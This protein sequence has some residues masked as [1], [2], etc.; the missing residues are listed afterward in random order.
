MTLFEELA[1]GLFKSSE[2]LISF[3]L[4]G[5]VALLG[6]AQGVVQVLLDCFLLFAY[7]GDLFSPS[8]AKQTQV[9]CGIYGG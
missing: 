5:L 1:Q 7:S 8:H 6:T 9:I 4:C 3:A 2:V